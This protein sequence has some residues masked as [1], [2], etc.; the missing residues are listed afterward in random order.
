MEAR[1]ELRRLRGDLWLGPVDETLG[2][3]AGG[4]DRPSARSKGVILASED[5]TRVLFRHDC[6]LRQ[7][8]GNR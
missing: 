4:G 7:A 8:G 2:R 3:I 1:D 5:A 6:L